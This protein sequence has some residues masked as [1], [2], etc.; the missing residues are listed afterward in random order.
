MKR[1]LDLFYGIL[2]AAGLM[3][4]AVHT[5]SAEPDAQQRNP[6]SA[7]QPITVYLAEQDYL[8][9]EMHGN[10]AAITAVIGSLGQNDVR[11]ATEAARN[12]DMSSYGDR[13]PNR[14][15]TLSGKLPSAWKPMAVSLRQGFDELAASIDAHEPMAKSLARISQLMAICDACLANFRLAVQPQK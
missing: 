8:L 4:P 9:G 11:G 7:R 13:D 1:G 14:P 3:A 12:R 15:A 2:L 5:H 10:L 6:S